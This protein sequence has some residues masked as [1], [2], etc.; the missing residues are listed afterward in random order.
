MDFQPSERCSEFKE[1]LTAFM[2]EHVYPAEATYER[3]LLESGDPHHQ[4]AVMEKLKV[5]A[6]EAGVWNMFLPD[7][8]HGAGLSNSDYA[9]LAEIL[10][11]SH[12]ASEACNCSAPDTGNMEV[13]HQFATPEQKDRWLTPLL[14][15]EIRSSFIMTEPDVASS[16]ATNIQ[17][18]IERDGD[19][20]VL[21]GRK[22]WVSGA[23]HPHCRILIVMG[24]TDAD[25]PSHQQQSMVL[26][27][28]DTPGVTIVRGLPVFG[29]QD[30]EG[31][32]E[33]RLEDVRV[34]AENLIA[35]EGE[36]FL[37]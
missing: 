6:R 20:Y 28:L 23:L 18:R 9:P 14:E 4:P 36:G 17:L 31:H 12:I 32:A 21:N 37:I 35:G 19:D 7:P 22:W 10:G 5:L 26:V 24:K 16:D 11:R 2:D 25:R 33:L 3:Q 27:P 8:E 13:L 34:P 30:Q 15:G 1:R 29:Y